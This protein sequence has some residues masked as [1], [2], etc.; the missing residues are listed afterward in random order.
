MNANTIH[1]LGSSTFRGWLPPL[2][3]VFDVLQFRLE[4][5]TPIPSETP[6]ETAEE[7]RG[8]LWTSMR[9]GMGLVVVTALVAGALPFG[10]NWIVAARAGA[11]LPLVQLSRAIAGRTAPL[12]EA[13]FSLQV[14]AETARTIAGIHP[15]F[16]SW[17]A[18]GLSALGVWLNQPLQWLGF[19]LV[20]GLGILAVCKLLGATTT[21]Q[22]FY[23][24]TSYAYPPL[25]L[26]MLHPIPFLGVVAAI[27]A[28]V[29]SFI[30][31][32]RIVHLITQLDMGRALLSVLLPGAVA[33]LIGL[34]VVGALTVS[35]LRI[36]MGM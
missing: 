14:W 10:V 3:W 17:L 5:M 9:Q 28:V 18:A 36:S 19:W 24:A 11:A 23:A 4:T 15:W 13:P 12:A 32:V 16:P 1:R 30:L 25:I 7:K 29:W 31:Y 20:Y 2:H 26:F 33:I 34:V 27:V 22:R 8:F 21:L 6:S 35:V